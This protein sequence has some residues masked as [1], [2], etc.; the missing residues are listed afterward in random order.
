MFC[1]KC[2]RENVNNA[3]FC[4]GCGELLKPAD[5][6]NPVQNQPET[7]TVNLG[8]ENNPVVPPAVNYTGVPDN[9]A[10]VSEGENNIPQNFQT[11]GPDNYQPIG[12]TTGLPIIQEA[13]MPTHNAAAQPKGKSKST[14]VLALVLS[15]VGVLLI[16]VAAFFMLQKPGDKEHKINKLPYDPNRPKNEE[17]LL[18]QEYSFANIN[19]L[20]LEGTNAYD[21]YQRST[22]DPY[23]TN[24]E[25]KF[26]EAQFLD[27]YAD[28]LNKT[29]VKFKQ[30]ADPKT[31]NHSTD[32]T[33]TYDS[34]DL[35][36]V[37]VSFVDRALGLYCE[38]LYDKR[39]VLS[40][41]DA[42]RFASMIDIPPEAIDS[43]FGGSENMAILESLDLEAY[44]PYFEK[45]RSLVLSEINPD[46]VKVETGKTYSNNNTTG[47][48]IS[49]RLDSETI[50]KILVK[51]LEDAKDDEKLMALIYSDIDKIGSLLK[52]S[53]NNIIIPSEGQFK[54]LYKSGLSGLIAQLNMSDNSGFKIDFNTFIDDEGNVINNEI[55]FMT[56]YSDNN[57]V[58]NIENQPS[59]TGYFQEVRV[60]YFDG[61]DA[62]G[63]FVSCTAENDK[64]GRS[65]E[66]TVD[67]SNFSPEIDAFRGVMIVD[68]KNNIDDISF[69][70]DLSTEGEAVSVSMEGDVEKKSSN[71]YESTLNFGLFSDSSNLGLSLNCDSN[72]EFKSV[73]MPDLK[74]SD[75][76]NVG[77]ATNTE[78]LEA[79]SQIYSNLMPLAQRLQGSFY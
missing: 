52:T 39:L 32:F 44:D 73:S 30:E 49:Y 76:F 54:S 20:P 41:D 78:I 40:K 36:T 62:Y 67:L 34:K 63:G 69:N 13:Q 71:L 9:T 25:F 35:T 53:G 58:L 5:N 33:L 72:V 74:S 61:Y 10:V 31:F 21:L 70:F 1:T 56:D 77:K 45:Y 3:A 12:S 8:S 26:N 2:G 6:Q 38:D 64:N 59:E 16:G 27:E 42:Q 66:T 37:S 24:G 57:L 7:P 47:R 22:K 4:S 14:L 79:F 50:S 65:F 48:E 60:T 55:M 28:I 18:A 43:F 11:P 75:S 51:I 68:S 23:V 19:V 15:I 17:F 46:D 29:S